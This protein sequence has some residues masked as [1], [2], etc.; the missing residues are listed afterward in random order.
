[1]PDGRAKR[2][3][4]HVMSAGALSPEPPGKPPCAI[5]NIAVLACYDCGAAIGL[6]R[7]SLYFSL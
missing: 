2:Y 7:G 6:F 5:H 3:T 4:Y 1:L